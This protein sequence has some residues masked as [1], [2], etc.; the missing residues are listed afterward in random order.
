MCHGIDAKTAGSLCKMAG[1]GIVVPTDGRSRLDGECS[2]RPQPFG[3]ARP[4]GTRGMVC[5]SFA[6]ALTLRFGHSHG[7]LSK[8]QPM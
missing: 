4:A 5:D 3:F 8:R 7:D 1:P 2:E 6:D